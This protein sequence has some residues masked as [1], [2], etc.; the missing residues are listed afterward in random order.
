[1]NLP[2]SKRKRRSENWSARE[3]ELL[4][5]MI[6]QSAHIIENKSNK[7]SVNI[8]K[9]KEWGNIMHRFNAITGKDRRDWELKMAW[10]R[11]K[12]MAKSKPAQ[13]EPYNLDGDEDPIEMIENVEDNT[14]N[15]SDVE[16]VKPS[17]STVIINNNTPIVTEVQI[18][19][20]TNQGTQ[21]EEVR[22]PRCETKKSRRFP[23]KANNSVKEAIA[24][25][26]VH[27]KRRQMQMM[28]VEHA[29]NVKIAKMKMKKLEM[30]IAILKS[31]KDS[32][33]N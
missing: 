14:D 8:M 18:T 17:T 24:R 21:Y 15:N 28:E 33:V 3:K 30:E 13:D 25:H 19:E 27:F 7:A 6:A 16:D 4:G 11:I 10:K 9:A 31:H 12:V 1:M 32:A 29:Y 20:I 2:H 5:R 26:Y 22:P 23:R